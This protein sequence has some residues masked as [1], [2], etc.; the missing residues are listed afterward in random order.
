MPEVSDFLDRFTR[1][2]N[3]VKNEQLVEYLREIAPPWITIDDGSEGLVNISYPQS[4]PIHYFKS[5][6]EL[7]SLRGQRVVLENGEVVPRGFHNPISAGD[8]FH[9]A[10]QRLGRSRKPIRFVKDNPTEFVREWFSDVKTQV[11]VQ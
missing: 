6:N 2:V 10:W 8:A 4:V 1:H 5:Q 11:N 7:S 3:R 9:V